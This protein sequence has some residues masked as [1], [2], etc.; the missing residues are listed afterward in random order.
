MS[1]R[2]ALQHVIE[3]RFASPVRLSTHWLRLRPAPHARAT[4]TAESLRIR[5]EPH[6]VN[7]TRDAFENRVAR[8]DFPELVRDFSLEVGLIA[9]LAG[10]DPFDFLLDAHAVEHP[11]EYDPQL[12]RE[13]EPYL[14]AGPAGPRLTWL[15]AALPRKPGNVVGRLREVVLAVHEAL[16]PARDDDAGRLDVEAALARGAGTPATLAWTLV[17]AFRSLGLAARFVSGYR[18]VA[19]DVEASASLHAWSEVHL[20]GAGWV[21]LDPSAALFTDDAYVPLACAPD[22]LRARPIFGFHEACAHESSERIVARLLVPAPPPSPYAEAAWAQIVATARTVDAGLD[23][24][25]IRLGVAR[26]LAFVS[27]RH[28]SLPEWR[29]TALGVTKREAAEALAGALGARLAPG[30]VVQTGQGEWIAGEPTPRWR[31]VCVGRTDGRVVWR[32]PRRLARTGPHAVV[33]PLRV[34][35]FVR[36]LARALG[37]SPAAPMAAYDDPLSR[38]GRS[39]LPMPAADELRDPD[40]RRALVDRLSAEH[41]GPPVG[42]ALPVA[43]DVV[44][45]GWRSAPWTFRRSRLYLLP[46][47]LPMGIRL[48]L[49]SLPAGDGAADPV[50]C[51]FAPRTPLG[52]FHAVAEN[53]LRRATSPDDGA[54]PRT[55]VCAEARDGRVHVFLPPLGRA[56]A[57]LALVAAVEVAAAYEDVAVVVEGYEPPEDPRLTRIAIEPDAGVLRVALPVA[58]GAVAQTQLLELAYGEAARLDLVAERLAADGT[59]EPTGVPAP[60]AIGGPSPSASPFLA[61]PS[62]VRALAIHWQRHPSLSY[63]LGSGVV[64]AAGD[65]ARVDEG[66]ADAL[67]ELATAL[68]RVPDGDVWPPWLGDRLLRHVLAD[69]T[70]DGR[71]AELSIERLYDPAD[72]NRRLGELALRGVGAPPCARTAAVQSLLVAALVARFGREPGHA[73]LV[74]WNGDLHD[75]FLLPSVLWSDLGAVL[76]DLDAAG[77]PLQRTWFQPFLDAVC[78]RLGR[79]Q[80]DDLTLELRRAHEPWPVLAEE[81]TGA[82]MARF[83]DTANARLEVRLGGHSDRHVVVCNGRRVP[84]RPLGEGNA[85]VGG[86]RYKRWQPPA[87]LHP[88]TWPVG[89]LVFDVVDAWTGWAIGGCTFVPAPPELAGSIAAPVVVDPSEG[90]GEGA[91]PVLVVPH[92]Q[93]GAAGW[94]DPIGSGVGPMALPSERVERTWT[95]DV[96]RVE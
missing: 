49:A 94:F 74:P 5:T 27:R 77:Y 1:R 51:P 65:V 56:E 38:L 75:R 90:P 39:G 32:D 52:D 14:F 20:P 84:L 53:A 61:R 78:P 10:V 88:T 86:V 80:L 85:S 44:R 79:L 93:R 83:V 59:N 60:I 62:L 64:G 15:C 73:T 69:A 63:L 12:R 41:A 21:G 72:A 95:L 82:G 23:A 35:S 16:A 92:G 54:A 33:A 58:E 6:F 67:A 31:L 9:E 43:W 68:E 13:L 57:Y 37:V 18:I 34:E 40:R 22:P 48:P 87:T 76:A 17:L 8:V 3:S 29:T 47:T 26:H 2:V 55:A 24:A 30:A 50:R 42:W 81:A 89:A 28:G 7:W 66:R 4:V 71:R 36:T 46:G 91:R 70:G 19:G 96:T 45:D 25:G 11:F